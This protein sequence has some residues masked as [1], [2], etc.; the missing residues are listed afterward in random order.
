[1]PD[2]H[3]R[4]LRVSLW[5][6]AIGLLSASQVPSALHAQEASAAASEPSALRAQE[7]STA[8]SEPAAL[9]AQ[10]ASGG[11]GESAEVDKEVAALLAQVQENTQA[12][13]LAPPVLRLYGFMDMGLQRSWGGLYKTGLSQSDALTF[14]LGNVNLYIDVMPSPQ[15]R[16]LTEVRFTTFPDGTESFDPVSGQFAKHNTT[17][18]DYASP[19]GGF[20]SIHWGA[21]V[22]ERAHIDWLP[23]DQLNVRVGY[24]LTPYG[25]WNVDHGTPTRIMLIPPIFVAYGLLPERQTGV[26]F[27][28]AF[29][30]LPWKIGYHLYVSNGRAVSVDVSDDKAIG[31][32]VYLQTRRPLSI[33]IGASAYWGNYQNSQKTIGVNDGVLGVVRSTSVAYQELAGGADLSL[34]I[35]PLRLRSEVV[36]N[37][38]VFEPG[39]R[40]LF[41]GIPRVNSLS[42]NTY[43]MAAFKLPWFG[44]EPLIYG[45]LI[46]LPYPGVAEYFA[47][48]SAGIN[49]Y[50]SANV[51]LRTQAGHVQ[52]WNGGSRPAPANSNLNLAAVRL[53]LTY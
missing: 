15:W 2:G 36:V 39:K 23:L 13:D 32:R 1:M 21:I 33:Q 11:A 10:E 4:E 16:G 22:L 38:T 53:I 29:H 17:V 51:T 44:L 6:G 20:L 34:D 9:H 3:R 50:I 12:A 30:A 27:F 14:V 41:G 8:A 5:L 40:E 45:E 28:G 26:E 18:L 7:A 24:F 19:S 46:H 37:R 43:V 25:I 47:G 52:G 35:G 31:G 49:W 48:V 42:Y